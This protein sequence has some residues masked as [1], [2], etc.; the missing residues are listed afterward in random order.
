ML[1]GMLHLAA[2]NSKYELSESEIKFWERQVGSYPQKLV[3]K[4]FAEYIASNKW[5]PQFCDLHEWMEREN[6]AINQRRRDREYQLSRER[7]WQ[8]VEAWRK[9]PEYEQEMADIRE[10]LAKVMAK[11][12]GHSKS[13]V[14]RDIPLAFSPDKELEILD[15]YKVKK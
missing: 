13:E 7:Q 3:E 8:R 11:A 15:R 12:K 2:A 10:R 1:A 5:M 14:K 4:F 6:E 9:S